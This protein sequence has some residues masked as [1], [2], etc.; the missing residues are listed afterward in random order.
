MEKHFIKPTSDANK[1][2][3]AKFSAAWK[4][5]AQLF[6]YVFHPLFIPVIAT[7]YLAFI[8]QGYFIGIT[9]HDKIF[10]V[11]KVA[12]NTI[13]FPGVTVL[14]LKAVGFIK[15]IF[16]KTQRERII[17]YVAANLF[18]FWMYLVFRN[19]PEVPSVL[20]T[21][22]F[23]IFL[24]SSVGLFANTYFKISMHALGMGTLSG[25]LLIIIFSG[26]PYNVFLAAMLV[27]LI[28][29]LVSTSRLI[30]SDH[31]L[32]DIYTGLFFGIMCQIIAAA[33]IGLS[34]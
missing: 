32:L 33:F 16:L 5:P 2:G 11:I 9:P 8:H 14:L 23:G 13:I 4:I 22:I 19:Q 34:A 15:S 26:S 28:S 27:F 17:P 3:E 30:V 12:V 7:W 1:L 24:S 6:S 29:G 10:I 20:T 25:L 18:Y 31:H 21:F